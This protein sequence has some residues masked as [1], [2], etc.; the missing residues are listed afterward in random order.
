MPKISWESPS[1][2]AIVKYWGKHGRQLPNNPS[3]SFTL[4]NAKSTTSVEY[5]PSATGKLDFTFLFEGKENSAFTA[6]IDKFLQSIAVEYFPFLLE[7][8]LKI[9][10][11]NT[12][13]HSSGIASSASSMSALALCLV[14]MQRT[15]GIPFGEDFLTRASIVSRL[16]SGSACRSVFPIAGL[17][18]YHPGIAHSSDGYAK[19]IGDEIH[20]VFRGFRDDI[21]IISADEK[22][23]SSTAGH[24]LMVNNPYAEAR[25][26]QAGSRMLDLLS[27]MKSGDVS[28]FGKMAED[29]AMTLHALMMC[30]DPS[31]ILMKTG[32][33]TA[34]EKVRAFRKD[35]G[36]NLYFTLD[37]GPNVH[38]LYP[39]S[40]A[41]EI[42]SF[43]MSELKPLCVDGRI[44]Q[45][46]VGNGPLKLQ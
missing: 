30:S 25:Y 26:S 42:Q 36:L 9:E 13:P 1:N 45:D 12:F 27:I 46:Q 17:W 20:E 28:A 33:L 37:A 24:I 11:S 23:V 43:I 8:N 19:G 6:K 41:K 32:T 35:T 34:I 38:L 10:S 7:Y 44:I 15:L 29:E 40:E 16:G 21:M 14:D 18:G 22:S 39:V 5:Q 4:Q 3:L 31:Y 2:I